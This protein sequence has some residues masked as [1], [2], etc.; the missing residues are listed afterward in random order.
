[1][2]RNPPPQWC[3]IRQAQGI[4]SLNKVGNKRKD[5]DRAT[6]SSASHASTHLAS[7]SIPTPDNSRG[8]PRLFVCLFVCLFAFILETAVYP[9][10]PGG[11]GLVNVQ[12]HALAWAGPNPG[13][14]S[15]GGGVT[16]P[17][18]VGSLPV[19]RLRPWVR[20]R[21]VYRRLKGTGYL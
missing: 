13:R 12:S 20:A 17:I 15:G 3:A 6:L 1:M 14:Q 16:P 10:A 7:T 11:D 9:F 18:L 19:P 5:T 8:E 4:T 21:S 2:Q